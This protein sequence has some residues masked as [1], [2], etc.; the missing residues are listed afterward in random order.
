MGS[1]VARDVTELT[2]AAQQIARH[3]R[4]QKAVAELGRFALE[5]H[6]LGVLMARRSRPR[7]R[8][9]DVE[10]GGILALDEDGQYADRRGRRRPPDGFVG[11]HQ[12]P[13]GKSAIA[14]LHAATGE[15]TVVEDM[16]TETRFEPAPCC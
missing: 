14:G 12:I 8:T 11:V 1:R 9:L 6:D 7:P 4:Q 10:G 13:V 15:P 3:A 16:A 2:H 5:S